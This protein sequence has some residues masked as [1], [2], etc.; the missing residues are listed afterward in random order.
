[1][2]TPTEQEHRCL[3]IEGL[4][5]TLQTAIG[6]GLVPGAGASFAVAARRLADQEPQ[7]SLEERAALRAVRSALLEPLRV[8]AQNAGID[9]AVFVA[10]TL[11]M[12]P[13]R[14]Y[15]LTR[16]QWVDPWSTSI[17]DPLGALEAAVETGLSLGRLYSTT[18]VLIH[19]TWPASSAEP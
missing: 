10:R 15:D 5:R 2:T 11:D 9:P 4:V 8:L 17:I 12:A 16:G 14:V 1:G 7:V 3:S 6:S 19:R 18:D 13:D